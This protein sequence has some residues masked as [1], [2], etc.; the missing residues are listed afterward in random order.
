M[1]IVA[2]CNKHV[3]LVSEVGLTPKTCMVAAAGA[4]RATICFSHADLLNCCVEKILEI[5]AVKL[6][7]WSGVNYSM[8]IQF[9]CQRFLSILEIVRTSFIIPVHTIY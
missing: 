7:Q 6:I 9:S 5:C 1:F 2:T 8:F 4:Q 3:T